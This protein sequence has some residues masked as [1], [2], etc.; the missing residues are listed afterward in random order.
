MK[1][2]STILVS[3]IALSVQQQSQFFEKEGEGLV[4]QVLNL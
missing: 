3:F 1:I 4:G 2:L